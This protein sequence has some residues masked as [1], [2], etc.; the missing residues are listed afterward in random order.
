[1]VS[2]ADQEFVPDE[3]PTCFS[4]TRTR[5]FKGHIPYFGLAIWQTERIGEE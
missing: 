5:E 3:L 4:E 1:M 2:G